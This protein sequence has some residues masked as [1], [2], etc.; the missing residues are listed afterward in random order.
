[1][2]PPSEGR[3]PSP[4]SISVIIT[5][6][7][8]RRF[9]SAA[10]D[11]VLQ[12]LDPSANDELVVM[13]NFE[14]AA[15]DRSLT[16]QGVRVLSSGSVTHGVAIARAIRESQGDLIAFLED[17]DLFVGDK[18]RRLRDIFASHPG[19]R[20]LHNGYLEID[21]Q[22]NPARPSDERRSIDLG[23]RGRSPEMYDGAEKR[24][25]FRRMGA[26]LPEAHLSCMAVSRT[27]VLG[28]L[29][30]L[31]R[32]SIGVDY[33]LFVCG[34]VSN[35]PVCVVPDKLTA[36]RRHPDSNSLSLSYDPDWYERLVQGSKELASA[37]SE[38]IERQGTPELAGLF[39]GELAAHE[40]FVTISNPLVRRRE[41]VEGIA[42]VLARPGTLLG[43]GRVSLVV[44]ALTYSIS[45]QR[46]RA[47]WWPSPG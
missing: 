3:V 16:D 5:A 13:K 19:T 20:F 26:A 33:F 1:M 32:L 39:E 45:P 2:P 24:R 4:P 28:A 7:N 40:L 47:I 36:Y 12:Q 25:K 29:D 23:M 11:S 42:K 9:L 38:L 15:L 46:A 22:G 35:G 10:I 37:T 21:E 30:L 8:R 34:V 43:V 27:S 6:Y 17:D 44:R 18:L 31:E 41:I 14:D